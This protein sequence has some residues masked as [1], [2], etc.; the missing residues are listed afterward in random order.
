MQ[1]GFAILLSV[2][3]LAAVGMFISTTLL[4]LSLS[5]SQTAG[6]LQ[7]STQA[8]ALA[9][10]CVEMALQQLILSNIYIGTGSAT[11][12]AGSCTYSVAAID[13]THDTIRGVGVVGQTTRRAQAIMYV[14]QLL[15]TS[16]QE[17][18]S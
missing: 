9:S 17:V 16:W 14:P 4:L 2:L 6:S 5:A 7:E 3:V 8:K 1:K 11:L 12:G 10:S 18:G 15:V 13:S